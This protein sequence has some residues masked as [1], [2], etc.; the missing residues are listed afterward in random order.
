MG[1]VQKQLDP[2]KRGTK[3]TVQA[4]GCPPLSIRWMASAG[5]GPAGGRPNSPPAG[6][7]SLAC[8][9]PAPC[10]P[11]PLPAPP[12]AVQCGPPA[13]ASPPT[14]G[15]WR[16]WRKVRVAKLERGAPTPTTSSSGHATLAPAHPLPL[17]LAISSASSSRSCWAWRLA[18][19]AAASSCHGNP[20]HDPW[21][22]PQ[23]TA[24]T[25]HSQY[26]EPLAS[27]SQTPF[28]G[29]PPP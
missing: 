22:S 16:G 4:P 27:S 11:A 20:E 15:R 8:R 13:A 12:P 25:F 10:C 17:L 21:G 23:P 29:L 5:G 2:Q 24:S 26:S 3:E 6:S 28:P 19:S 14:P 7:P 18:R 1:R 9:S